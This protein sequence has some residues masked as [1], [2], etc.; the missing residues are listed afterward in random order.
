MNRSAD[1]GKTIRGEENRLQSELGRA[2]SPRSQTTSCTTQPFQTRRKPNLE[3]P[4]V[5][6]VARSTG[7]PFERRTRHAGRDIF[8]HSLT[9]LMLSGCGAKSSG[10]QL[11]TFTVMAA[12]PL[13]QGLG[14]Q[15]DR[16]P[17]VKDSLRWIDSRVTGNSATSSRLQFCSH[18]NLFTGVTV[19]VAP[20]FLNPLQL[21][22]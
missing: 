16:C 12:R 5:C 1:A 9:R 22:S 13:P 21:L 20:D 3:S 14:L 15:D 17:S 7:F 10:V 11:A 19:P 8:S 18:S 2:N 4:S 6:L